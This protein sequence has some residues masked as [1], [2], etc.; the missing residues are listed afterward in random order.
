VTKPVSHKRRITRFALIRCDPV[1]PGILHEADGRKGLE[2]TIDEYYQAFLSSRAAAVRKRVNDA[3]GNIKAVAKQEKIPRSSLTR[4][5]G[6][7]LGPDSDPSSG[8]G[9]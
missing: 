7:S 5:L 6:Q 2:E 3:G 4:W 1:F 9:S 8:K